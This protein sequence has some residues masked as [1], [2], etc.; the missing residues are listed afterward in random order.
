MGFE[1][2]FKSWAERVSLSFRQDLGL[3]QDSPLYPEQLAECLN[4]QLCT[5]NQIPNLPQEI[6]DQLL[7][8]DPSGWSAVS[9]YRD[10]QGLVIY[11]PTHS[12]GRQSSD[13]MHELSH[14]IRDHKPATIIMN[15]DGSI[16]MRSYN[17][18][19]EEEANWL[20]WT[21]LLPREALLSSIKNSLS[22][23]QIADIF[24][25]SKTLVKFR[26]SVT[27]IDTQIRSSKKLHSH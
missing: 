18:A 24:K 10:G 22:I 26:L 5:P 15:Q 17:Q 14:V 7:K 1:R 23:D 3:K 13:I 21:L 20:A 9:V 8:H 19:Q 16:V 11:N 12:K 4:I 6:L 25:V 2:G 27:G